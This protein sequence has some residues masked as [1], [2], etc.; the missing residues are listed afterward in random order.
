MK[1]FVVTQM[2]LLERQTYAAIK[3]AIRRIPGE[4]NLPHEEILNC[5][6]LV[7]AIVL[8]KLPLQLSVVDGWCLK[9]WS[10]SWLIDRRGN[11][12]DPYPVGMLVGFD[13]GASFVAKELVPAIYESVEQRRRE[14]A[15]MLADGEDPP[16]LPDELRSPVESRFNPEHLIEDVRYVYEFFVD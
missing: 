2:S 9:G 1:P 16:C 15:Q 13:D 4:L 12:Y 10:H 14:F 6:I 8:L 3:N 11:V 5:H 7:R